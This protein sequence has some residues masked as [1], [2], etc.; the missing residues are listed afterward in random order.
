MRTL[1]FLFC[2]ALLAQARGE[3]PHLL[4][5]ERALAFGG[6]NAPSGRCSVRIVPAPGQPPGTHSLEV[7]FRLDRHQTNDWIDAFYRPAPPLDLSASRTHRLW[8]RAAQPSDWLHIKLCDPDNPGANRSALEGPLRHHGQPLPAGEW[9]ALDLELPA[10][11]ERRDGIDYFGFYLPSANEAIPPG[12][13]LVFH[14]GLF[15]FDLP[16]R[17]PWPPAEGSETRRTRPV[18]T[19]PFQADGPWILVRDHNNQTGR[20][21]RIE[22]GAI[23]FDSDADGW[24]EYLWSD[25][26]K[27]ALKPLTTY[28]LEYDY[29]ILRGAEGS[30]DPCFYSL[31]RA[32]GTIREDVGWARWAPPTGSRGTRILTFTTRDMPD[33]FLNFGIRHHGSIRL[34]NLSVHEVLPE[35][36]GGR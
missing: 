19:G 18:F 24:N 25:P 11:T 14:L 7:R 16:P 15:P 28:R 36:G 34:S 4:T 17:P 32:R 12:Q 3:P 5:C 30:P 10:E 26:A 2:L 22:D 31:V 1:S 33:Y 23:L 9:V 13:D 20:A 6:E 27:L 35:E 21:A 29:E 8:V